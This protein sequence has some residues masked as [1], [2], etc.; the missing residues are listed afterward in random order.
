MTK[1]KRKKKLPAL[2]SKQVIKFLTKAG[3]CFKR[4]KGSH[5]IYEINKKV[6][7][8]PMH[9]K[10]TIPPGTLLSILRQ[11]GISKEEFYQLIGYSS[12][13]GIVSVFKKVVYLL[14]SLF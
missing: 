7:V 6:V 11:A 1:P 14:S 12:M 8:V 5:A 2:S 13:F 9:G 10:N 4:Q 3:A